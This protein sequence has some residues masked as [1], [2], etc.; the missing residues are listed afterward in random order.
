MMYIVGYA[1]KGKATYLKLSVIRQNPY[2][3]TQSRQDAL[4]S[5]VHCSICTLEKEG[6]V[7]NIITKASFYDLP[8][9]NRAFSC[10]TTKY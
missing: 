7:Q 8:I 2:I 9:L 1:K 10:V 5:V 3:R 4:L 6:V